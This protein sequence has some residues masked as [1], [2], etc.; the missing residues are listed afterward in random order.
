MRYT[1]DHPD[2]R[3]LERAIGDL[4]KKLDEEARQP[5]KPVAKTMSPA[6][7]MRQ[8]KVNELQAQI[9]AIDHQISAN[10]AEDGRLKRSIADLEAK[11]NAG[12]AREAELV[13]LMRDHSTLSETYTSLLKKYEDSKLAENLVR[14]QI[15]EQ[16][17]VIDAASLP[18]KPYNSVQRLG[19]LSA[20]PLV[21]LVLGLGFIGLRE[22]RD[23][24]FKTDEDV[25]RLVAVPV[26]AVV[27]LLASELER[28]A[29]R[30]RRMLLDVAGTAMTLL[31][32][33]ALVFWRWQ[34]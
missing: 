16:F 25:H 3:S 31:V 8:R 7:A 29:S 21:G 2:I 18:E 17:K 1:P 15:G 12:P 6:E 22:Y 26:L 19:L 4:E 10:Q 23:S 11:V 14:R 20:G 9:D 13:E 30:R 28:N 34:S 33:A 5:P 27:P 24:S 32:V